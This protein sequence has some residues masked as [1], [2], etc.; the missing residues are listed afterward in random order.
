MKRIIAWGFALFVVG[1][2]LFF[3]I[4]S[5]QGFETAALSTVEYE[6]RSRNID[7]YFH[8]VEITELADDVHIEPSPDGV[9][10]V[11]YVDSSRSYHKISVESDCLVISCETRDGGKWYDNIGIYS[12]LEEHLLILYLPEAEYRQLRVNTASADVYAGAAFGFEK[13][14]INSASGDVDLGPVAGK[15]LSVNT[16]SGDI[17]LGRQDVETIELNAASGDIELGD[18]KVSIKLSAGTVSGEID[19]TDTSCREL[20][21]GTASGQIELRNVLASGE[22]LIESASGDIRLD[23]CDADSLRLESTSG[24]IS[25]ILL[26]GKDFDA[27]TT[28]G[29][30]HLPR[31]SRGGKCS[32]ETTSGDINFDIAS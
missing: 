26:S 15:S 7:Q 11:E 14:E 17:R 20:E 19:L 30:I 2:T 16:A 13:A 1:A 27:D 24:Y 9:C 23:Y 5:N 31:G 25:G 12:D 3:S 10:R 22:M 28:S 8:S 21:V 18:S 6:K 4:W 32:I 29:D